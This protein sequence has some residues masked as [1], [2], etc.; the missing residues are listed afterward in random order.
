MC[1]RG[2]PDPL[3]LN[4]SVGA[5]LSWERKTCKLGGSSA[6]CVLGKL[7]VGGGG[8]WWAWGRVWGSSCVVGWWGAVGRG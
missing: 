3:G 7:G 4:V 8:G 2:Q 6:L 5:D 1:G